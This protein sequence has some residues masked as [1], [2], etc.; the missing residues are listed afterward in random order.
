MDGLSRRGGA[1]MIIEYHRPETIE[2]ALELLN[3]NS[4]YTVPLGGGTILSRQSKP[5]MAV[6][7]LQKLGLN[8]LQKEGDHLKIGA[9][10][11]IQSLVQSSV[12][13]KELGVVAKQ[14][15]SFN[16]RQA[17]TIGG[18]IAARDGLSPLLTV[19][20][21]LDANLL[22]LPGGRLISLG[23]WLPVRGDWKQGLIVQAQIQQNVQLR[24]EQ[25]GRTPADQPII[26]VAVAKW[27]SG[28]TRIT[29]GG[30]M[31]YPV[32]ALDGPEGA[33]MD[34]IAFNAYSHYRNQKYSKTYIQE[35]TKTLIRRLSNY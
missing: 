10:T 35:T 16:L 32:L 12:I 6:V 23:E 17:A 21:A 14:E 5:D 2:A 11:T 22:W 9:M 19:L 4:P 29:F 26:S 3:R 31:P 28:R 13:S 20:L 27:P 1:E 34:Q 15:A 33:D 18:T 25:V 30:D 8:A 24:Y 7:D